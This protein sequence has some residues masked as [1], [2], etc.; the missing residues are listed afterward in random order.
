MKTSK[1]KKK[2]K[3]GIVWYCHKYV[4]VW[5][6]R[7]S[8]SLAHLSSNPSHG[9]GLGLIPG[10][11]CWRKLIDDGILQWVWMFGVQLYHRC[12]CHAKHGVPVLEFALDWGLPLEPQNLCPLLGVI[13]KWQ[14]RVPSFS[15]S[16]IIVTF[17]GSGGIY[18]I[19]S[20]VSLDSWA[21]STETV[22]VSLRP[23]K[24]PETP[25]FPV[26]L[27]WTKPEPVRGWGSF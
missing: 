9:S 16:P 13:F 17:G 22:C 23:E 15:P 18:S 4:Q 5:W 11:A 12:H 24:Q 10:S 25:S 19:E 20:V 7:V 6:V 1:K 2:K 26:W 14:E 3:N 27:D 8:Q 21:W